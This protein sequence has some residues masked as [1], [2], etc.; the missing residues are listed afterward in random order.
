MSAVSVSTLGEEPQEDDEM[1]LPEPLASLVTDCTFLAPTPEEAHA[2]PCRIGGHP[3]TYAF[4]RQQ[5]ALAR[6]THPAVQTLQETDE[7][8][9]KEQG[10][11]EMDAVRPLGGF[12]R[13]FGAYQSL[14]LGLIYFIAD[15]QGAVDVDVR[16]WVRKGVVVMV[17]GG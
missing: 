10:V 5:S 7:E 12:E 4:A 1:L 3:A 2:L 17:G 16:G 13:F 15:V 11:G 9:E 14:G 8:E 6:S